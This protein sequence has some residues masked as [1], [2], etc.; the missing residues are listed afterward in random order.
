[1]ALW[2][3][4]SVRKPSGGR[5]RLARKKR[6]FEVAKEDVETKLGPHVQKLIR[7]KGRNQKVKL[8]ATDKVNVMDPKTG[9]AKAATIK[10]VKENPANIH[11]VRRNILTKG[12]V[13]E[14][15][16]GM[17]RITSRP[18]QTGALSGV[19]VK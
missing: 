15:D 8:L 9:K 11:Y 2:Q 7:A 5:L 14:T 4:Q 13:V 12:A 19:L 18:G 6:R 16:A 10:T 17:V 3:G 1:M